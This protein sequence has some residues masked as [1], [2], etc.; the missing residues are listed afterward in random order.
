MRRLKGHVAADE[1]TE[2]EMLRKQYEKLGC[3]DEFGP[4]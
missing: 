4:A 1:L 2:E 3:L